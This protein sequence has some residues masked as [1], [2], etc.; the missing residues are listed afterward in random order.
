MRAIL[1]VTLS[2]WL[3][4]C[5]GGCGGKWHPPNRTETASPQS[6][7]TLVECLRVDGQGRRIYERRD[8]PVRKGASTSVYARDYHRDRIQEGMLVDRALLPLDR[9][10]R[11]VTTQ[12]ATEKRPKLSFGRFMTIFFEVT[13]PLPTMPLDL[14]LKQ[15]I[16]STTS[17]RYF[18]YL[19][20]PAMWG[21]VTRE[22]EIEGY[23]D[24]ECPAGR[25]E[26]CL[27][28]RVDLKVH[29]P[30]TMMADLKHYVWLSPRV[31]EVRRLQSLTGW[32]LIFLFGSTQEY[33]LMSYSSSSA[34]GQAELSPAA[35]APGWKRGL[36]VFDRGY[37]YVRI[38]GMVV[39]LADGAE[40]P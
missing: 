19:G 16:Q 5:G 21:T 35:I 17:I 14:D 20:R 15:P 22:A 31:G 3:A 25:F 13:D 6:R 24:V 8:Y 26:D 2:M 4:I 27:R 37:P 23:E 38:G 12:P 10:L 33:R 40:G 39:D 36:V 7:P 18:D 29:F 28:V 9:Y 11:N 34:T 30:W 1:P 32:F